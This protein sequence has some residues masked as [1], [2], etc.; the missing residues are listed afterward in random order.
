MS[1]YTLALFAHILGIFGLFVGMGLQWTIALRLR[2]AQTLSQ[3]RE[4]SSLVRGVGRLSAV[5]GVV[6]LAAGIYMMAVSWSLSTPWIVVSL[7]AI[8]IMMILGMGVTAR[9]LMAIR[10][11]VAAVDATAEVISQQLRGQIHDPALWISAQMAASTALG[12]VFLMTAKPGLNGSLLATAIA[13]TLGAI[14]GV[15][16]VRHWQNQRVPSI[17]VKE[18]AI[19]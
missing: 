5:S 12:V 10:R 15:V 19:I 11:A 3:V 18:E 1:L 7:A 9:R 14:V 6:I 17:P 13:L 4:W 8:L 2:R 16:S